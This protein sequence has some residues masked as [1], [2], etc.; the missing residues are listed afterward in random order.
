MIGTRHEDAVGVLPAPAGDP[1]EEAAILAKVA[2]HRPSRLA[3]L[4]PGFRERVGATHVAGKYH[5]TETPFLLEGAEKL[6]EL[7]TRLGKF[8]FIPDSIANSYPF[9]SQWG[10]SRTFVELAKADYFQRLFA[11][12]FATFILEAHAPVESRWLQPGLTEARTELGRAARC[13]VAHA[14]EVNRVLD[15]WN[16]IPTMTRHV[17]PGVELDLVSS[18]SFTAMNPAASSLTHRSRR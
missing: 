4:P 11:L 9:N 3:T 15:A 1:P 13:R 17:L 14:A 7:G 6:L 5:L 18:G 8:W 10:R 2:A 16:G 12:P